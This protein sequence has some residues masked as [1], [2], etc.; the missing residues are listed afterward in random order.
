ML[1]NFTVSWRWGDTLKQKE[2][3]VR[4]TIELELD[5]RITSYIERMVYRLGFA[6]KSLRDYADLLPKLLRKALS[7]GA[8]VASWDPKHVEGRS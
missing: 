7:A 1:Y 6:P 8:R 5:E 3:K 2:R 4:M